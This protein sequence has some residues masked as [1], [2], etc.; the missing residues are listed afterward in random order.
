MVSVT[1]SG[2]SASEPSGLASMTGSGPTTI[3]VHNGDGN[4]KLT[5]G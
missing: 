4:G 5:D 2:T 3:H 1:V